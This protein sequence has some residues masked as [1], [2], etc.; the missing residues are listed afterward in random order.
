MNNKFRNFAGL[1]L[2]LT[3][4][5]T[6]N[7]CKKK[8]QENKF[9]AFEQSLTNQDSVEV[10]NL[11]NTFFS[12]AEHGQYAEAAAMLVRNKVDSVYDQPEPLTNKDMED[13]KGLLS[14]LPIKS[15]HIDYLKFNENYEN[16]VKCSAL[17]AEAHD[18]VPEIKTVYYFKPV[19]YLGKWKLCL[20]DSHHGD[21]PVLEGEQRD[22]MKSEYAKEMNLKKHHIK[23]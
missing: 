21:H 14:S 7:S 17:I 19:K 11:V 3:L 20:M 23:Q 12:F 9:T 1:L 22:S 18:N 6:F 15:H 13:V 10:T 4:I 16:E 2:V 5:L 8:P